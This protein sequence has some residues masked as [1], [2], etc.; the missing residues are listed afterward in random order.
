VVELIAHVAH[1]DAVHDAAE[2]MP[3]RVEYR[4]TPFGNRF[5]G[6]LD[7]IDRLQREIDR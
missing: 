6:V 1:V 7:G 5:F 3:P 2:V 4:L